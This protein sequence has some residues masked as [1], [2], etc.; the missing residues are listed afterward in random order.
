MDQDP[1]MG[2]VFV[3]AWDEWELPVS[4]DDAK[5]P[6]VFWSPGRALLDS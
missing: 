2:G 6:V 4:L 3:G 1:H 5:E